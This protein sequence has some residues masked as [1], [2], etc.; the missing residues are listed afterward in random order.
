M[1]I[2]KYYVYLDNNGKWH[3][4]VVMVWEN[5]HSFRTIV[6]ADSASEAI[7]KAKSEYNW[8]NTKVQ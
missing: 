3:A 4:R 5:N 8:K 6:P 1:A 2:N 7:K